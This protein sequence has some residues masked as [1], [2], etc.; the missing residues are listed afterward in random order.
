MIMDEVQ[1]LKS[2]DEAMCNSYDV[3]VGNITVEEL[4][5]DKGGEGL[6][7]AHNVELAPTPND[8][9]NLLKYFTQQ[10][11]FERCVELSKLDSE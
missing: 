3:I 10:E 7:F 8:I 4:M 5:L 6:I 11:D 2:L 9:D 1:A